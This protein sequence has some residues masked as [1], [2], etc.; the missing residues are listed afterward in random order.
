MPPGHAHISREL[1]VPVFEGEKIVA[2]LGVGNKSADYNQTD[3]EVVSELAKMAWDILGRKEAERKF[4]ESQRILK[5]LID[6]LP[7]IVFRCSINADMLMNIEF[8]SDGCKEITGYI[9][10]EFTA[11]SFNYLDFVHPDDCNMVAV[12][13]SDF[14]NNKEPYEVQFRIIHKNKSI[15]WIWGRGIVV[16]SKEGTSV[17]VEGFGADITELRRKDSELRLFASAIHQVAETIVITDTRGIIKYVNPSFEKITGYSSL[18]AIGAKPCILKSGEHGESFYHELWATIKSG[19]IWNGRFINR[20]KDGSLYT[21]DASISPVFDGSGVI[22]DFVAVKRDITKELAMET[23]LFQAQKME[24]IGSLAG[25]IAHDFNNILFP[26][27]G[28]SDILQQDLPEDSPLQDYV[29]EILTASFRAKELVKQ[30]LAFSRQS[31]QEK[32]VSRIQNILHEVIRF[33]KATLPSTI[34]VRTF[35]EKACRP[36]LADPTQIHQIV[37]NLVTNALHAMEENGGILS[38]S[39]DEIVM[40][41]ESSLRFSLKQGLHLRLTVSDTGCG[42]DP[43]IQGRIFDP[44]FTTKENGKGTGIGLAVVHGLVKSH[45]GDIEL[46]S[47][48]GEGTS[49]IIYFPCLM[50][51]RKDAQKDLLTPIPRGSEKILV[52][53]DE[54]AIARM[55]RQMLERLGYTVTVRTSSSEAFQLF[56]DDPYRFDL[57]I[58][59]MTMPKM[60]GDQLSMEIKKIRTGIPIIICTGFSEKMDEDKARMLGIEGF[61]MKPILQNE[62]VLKVREVLDNMGKL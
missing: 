19:R 24:A 54:E 41:I 20:K 49:F 12:M 40:D 58:T 43:A 29:S 28:F 15:R 52:V 55:G 1:A 17:T 23:Q 4:S 51:D 59:D 27:I 37:M 14:F 13:I 22:T 26:L 30:I 34:T 48:P 10:D 3:V 45:G 2:I 39:L 62:L 44:Y 31:K 35:I 8:I 61:V 56:K 33:S 7:G 36:V 50:E 25:G 6:N 60:T 9:P 42:I 21:E 16:S 46:Q 18:E 53:D 11:S 5:T 32:S 47:T 38:I 57:V